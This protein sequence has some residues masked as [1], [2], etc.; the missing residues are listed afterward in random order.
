LHG[1]GLGHVRR[2][3]KRVSEVVGRA[4]GFLIQQSVEFARQGI[5]HQLAERRAQGLMHVGPEFAL[6]VAEKLVHTLYQ[7]LGGYASPF[8]GGVAFGEH[9]FQVPRARAPVARVLGRLADDAEQGHFLVGHRVLELSGEL[10]IA[11]SGVA[12]RA[13]V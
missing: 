10:G 6:D 11:F 2:G 13:F 4:A 9:P 5:A 3:R 12:D 7:L 1:R 8:A